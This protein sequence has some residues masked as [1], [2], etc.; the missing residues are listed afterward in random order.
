MAEKTYEELE[1][2]LERYK[3][4]AILFEYI[5]NAIPEAVVFSDLD[6][7]IQMVNPACQKLLGYTEQELV[8]RKSELFYKNSQDFI[9]HGITRFNPEAESKLKSYEAEYRKKNGEIFPAETIG[10]VVRDDNGLPMGFLGIAKDITERKQ[11]EQAH[12]E[13]QDLLEKRILKRSKELLNAQAK[14]RKYLDVAAVMLVALNNKGEITLINQEGCN[15]L[16]VTEDEALD[17]NWFD[18]FIPQRMRDEVKGVFLQL[19]QGEESSARFYENP[20]VNGR[21]EERLISFKNTV[22]TDDEGNINGILSSG[23]DISERRENEAELARRRHRLEEVNTALDVLLQ[24]SGEAKQKIEKDIMANITNLIN[25]HISKLE[26]ILEDNR[27]KI[28][29]NI[30]KANLNKIT[31]SFSQDINFKFPSLTPREIQVVDFI[32]HGLTNK[33]IAELLHLSTRT[34]ETYRDNIRV[35]LGIKNKRIN[36]RSYLLSHQ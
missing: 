25:P 21:G 20:I 35:K 4:N 31:A 32:R 5:L 26:V 7:H 28:F 10:T 3:K 33:D 15:L 23:E 30:L 17:R 36:L 14:F 12:Y 6:R 1:K 29:L 11:A 24:Q 13:Y 9:Q 22:L 34:I 27:A 18:H 16:K 2:E 8:G 19:M